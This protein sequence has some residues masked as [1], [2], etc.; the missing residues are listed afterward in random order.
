LVVKWGRRFAETLVTARPAGLAAK[1]QIKAGGLYAN[2][3]ETL[4]AARPGA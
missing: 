1:T 4:V 3:N 2:H